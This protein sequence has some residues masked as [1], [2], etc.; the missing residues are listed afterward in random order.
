MNGLPPAMLQSIL[1]GN[2]GPLFPLASRGLWRNC[3]ARPP[4]GG[5]APVGSAVRGACFAS[6]LRNLRLEE[7]SPNGEI[8]T[9]PRILPVGQIANVPAASGYEAVA[10]ALSVRDVP[11]DFQAPPMEDASSWPQ[12]RALF[13]DR[14]NLM[15]KV[16]AFLEQFD[17]EE[18]F[19]TEAI[20]RHLEGFPR[21]LEGFL[22]NRDF[23]AIGVDGIDV[24]HLAPLLAG[25]L[26][27]LAAQ[28]P[29]ARPADWMPSGQETRLPA[30]LHRVLAQLQVLLTRLA[31]A[32]DNPPTPL[33]ASP[34][35]AA[36]DVVAGKAEFS[37]IL[38]HAVPVAFSRGS[39][40]V[41][42]SAL[43]ELERIIQGP[44]DPRARPD[45]AGGSAP[46]QW[47]GSKE[48]GGRS[49]IFPHL[50]YF[51]EG[52]G[53]VS[54]RTGLEPGP[55]RAL[56]LPPQ[57]QADPAG[58]LEQL[59]E[60]IQESTQDPGTDRDGADPGLERF[61][62]SRLGLSGLSRGSLMSGTGVLR[63][64]AAAGQPAALPDGQGSG[65]AASPLSES[66]RQAQVVMAH[67]V[68]RMQGNVAFDPDRLRAVLHL[69]PPVL[70]R[71]HVQLAIDENQRLQARVTADNP[72]TQDFLE[73][74]QSE[75][76]QGLAR[77]GFLPDQ[78]EIE[79]SREQGD[80]FTQWLTPRPATIA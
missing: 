62:L 71:V 47:A 79:F 18:G 75:L 74:N 80:A 61:V 50:V 37:S 54:A 2:S 13:G 10:L 14:P 6:F 31:P 64:E 38:L 52:Q 59:I 40:T 76:R 41:P 78:V 3:L 43:A 8:G 24:S 36:Q 30:R 29:N 16:Q 34:E 51:G 33:G 11:Q 49:P 72:A 70:G 19:S 56:S 1:G 73:Q 4:A 9:L 63:A 42:A 68:E 17:P 15:A 28:S 65:S 57:A 12:L 48:P 5:A 53:V 55:I 22:G 44:A 69:E 39:G 45:P 46:P 77:Q 21:R 67:M 23:D 32:G 26:E 25:I 66:V 58:V 60:R 20:A 27:N 7:P 35:A